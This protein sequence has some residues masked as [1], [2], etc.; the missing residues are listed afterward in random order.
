MSQSVS[1]SSSQKSSQS[2]GRRI[3]QTLVDNIA[4]IKAL[5]EAQAKLLEQKKQLVTKSKPLKNEL[6]NDLKDGTAINWGD[7]NLR[8][9]RVS[10][11]G[12]RKP[13]LADVYKAVTLVLGNA[14]TE[15]LKIR[16]ADYREQKKLNKEKYASEHD[17][18]A[19][20]DVV[21]RTKQKR[22]RKVGSKTNQ[23]K[24]TPKPSSTNSKIRYRKRVK[25]TT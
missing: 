4:K 12:Q 1:Q 15:K 5:E 8:V 16:V 14:V 22:I 6:R 20:P 11:A 3:K 7:R 25:N 19:S 18:D 24:T 21:V 17:T 9:E 2:D 23:K 10:K 13:A